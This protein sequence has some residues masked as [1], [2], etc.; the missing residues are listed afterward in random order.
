M[1]LEFV[2]KL[3][4][5]FAIFVFGYAVCVAPS[6]ASEAAIIVAEEHNS[7]FLPESTP[8]PG[9]VA[10]I[11]LGETESQPQAFYKD[12]PVMVIQKGVS[13]LAIVGISLNEKLGPQE[14]KI[15]GRESTQQF[16]VKAK[17]YKSQYI[18]LKTNKHVNLS[19]KNL[20]RHYKEKKLSRAALNNWQQDN[21][22]NLALLKPVKGEYSSPFGLRRFFNNQPRKP[23][24]GVDI[25]AASGTPI[26]A[27][28]D[29]KVTLV[30][31]FFFNG[32]TVFIDHG[33]GLVTM[34]CHMSEIAVK[35]GQVVKKGELIAK[36]GA[37]GRVT[38]AHLHWG[39]TLNG[40]MVDPLL[41]LENS[42][43]DD[44]K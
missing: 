25:A 42:N 37:T 44:E 21:D 29:G 32:K 41:F 14:L 40:N 38:G 2:V 10:V 8:V 12:K 15:I 13:W 31:E 19:K 36:V 6:L 43:K 35:N 28:A 33:Y 16:E 34:Y 11:D 26:I 22:A 24:S 23:H 30:G 17:E 20:D 18:K 5:V 1:R 3:A 9:G 39:V 27:P 4:N 7:I